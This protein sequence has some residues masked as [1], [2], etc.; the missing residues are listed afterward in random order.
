[1]GLGRAP[2]RGGVAGVAHHHTATAR[3]MVAEGLKPGDRPADKRGMTKENSMSPAAR[4]IRYNARRFTV[5]DIRRDLER[6]LH[7][8]EADS[9]EVAALESTLKHLERAENS[10]RLARDRAPAGER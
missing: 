10:L 8:F 9:G 1:M 3:G 7:T 5:S 6:L 4:R 2:L